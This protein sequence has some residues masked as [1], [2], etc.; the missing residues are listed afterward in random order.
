MSYRFRHKLRFQWKNTRFSHPVYFLPRWRGFLGIWYRRWGRKSRMMGLPGRRRSSTISSVVW[1]QYTNVTER[2]T[3]TGR[4]Q[5]PRLRTASR[6]KNWWLWNV[7]W[8]PTCRD[9]VSSW[10]NVSLMFLLGLSVGG[11]QS[12]WLS[13]SDTGT[14]TES[15]SV[16]SKST[17]RLPRRKCRPCVFNANNTVTHK[18]YKLYRILI[19]SDSAKSFLYRRNRRR[20]QFFYHCYG[21][22]H[23]VKWYQ[24]LLTKVYFAVN[25]VH[26]PVHEDATLRFWNNFKLFFI[27]NFN[28]T[29]ITGDKLHWYSKQ[30]DPSY[31][32]AWAHYLVN[33]CRL[34]QSLVSTGDTKIS[35]MYQ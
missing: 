12:T 2:R 14:H 1:V 30:N 11:L 21:Y 18:Y 23:F 27:Y 5:R 16:M 7:R 19:P 24:L 4:Q 20:L 9:K 31:I 13:A 35:V 22:V 3:D 32:C 17:R 15:P 25:T 10:Q 34:I 6:G 28:L 29:L 33:Y 8:P 26:T